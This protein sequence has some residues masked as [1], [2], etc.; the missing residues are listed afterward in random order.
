MIDLGTFYNFIYVSVSFKNN[1]NFVKSLKEN[2]RAEIPYVDLNTLNPELQESLDSY[3]YLEADD[4]F[5]KT[6]KKLCSKYSKISFTV[7]GKIRGKNIYKFFN[8][9]KEENTQTFRPGDKIRLVSGEFKG[10]I[11]DIKEIQGDNAV[12]EFPILKEKKY[13]TVPLSEVGSFEDSFDLFADQF[14]D[15]ESAFRNTGAC[16]NLIIDGNDALHR[17]IQ[18][19]NNRYNG[20]KQYVGAFYGF[21]FNLLKL[22]EFYPEYTVHVV[23]EDFENTPLFAE[24]SQTYKD[25]FALNFK[26]AL[27]FTAA[28][29]YHLHYFPRVKS[30][31]IIADL[32]KTF[33]Q[34]DSVTDSFVF[35]TNSLLQTLASKKTTLFYPKVTFR[36]NAIYLT[37]ADI[38][39]KWGVDSLEKVKWVLVMEGEHGTISI[40]KFL[41]KKDSAQKARKAEYH[42]A[43]QSSKNVEELKITLSKN[44]KYAEYFKS[45]IFDAGMQ[46]L[47]FKPL[48]VPCNFD[49]KERNEEEALQVLEETQMYKEIEYW[50]RSYRM[51]RGLW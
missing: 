2:Y 13:K 12:I 28:I 44:P 16:K 4:S 46:M 42:P 38:M 33:E 30:V 45:G 15:L 20:N 41:S 23:F 22:K 6:Y 31:D 18:N 21:F 47:E 3:I 7:L 9:C 36:G 37:P 1:P 40:N 29:G 34:T 25:A 11:A 17:S 43:I 48:P 35:S 50:D 14:K 39:E 5:V 10:L 27:R 24:K 51:L 8:I 32:C 49:K 19:N 26:W